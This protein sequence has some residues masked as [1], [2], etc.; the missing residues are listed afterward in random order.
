MYS[1]V[2]LQTFPEILKDKPIFSGFCMNLRIEW[3]SL[4]HRIVSKA[5]ELKLLTLIL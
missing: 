2:K 3:T 4:T 1:L 5:I